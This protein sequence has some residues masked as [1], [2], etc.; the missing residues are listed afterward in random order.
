MAIELATKYAGY[1]DELFKDEAKVSLFTN[2]DLK[3]ENAHTVKVYSVSTG[4]MND[5]GR[6]GSPDSTGN[7]PSRYG[8]V[9]PLS[10]TTQTMPLRKDRSFTFEIDRLDI[11]ETAGALEAAKALARQLREVVVPEVD[12][13]A[14]A[15]M[16]HGAGNVK[17]AGTD[18]THSTVYG[19]ILDGTETMDAAEV[20]EDNRV[21]IV[22]PS[23]WALIKQRGILDH[24]DV[25]TEA[26]LNG[27]IA[28][29]DGMNVVRIAAA[30]LPSGVD[31][32]IAHPTATV[33]A[34]KL[35]DYHIH[36]NPPGI[37]GSLVEGRI[38][39]DAYV[40]DNKK[41]GI[42]VHSSKAEYTA[43]VDPSGNP[44]EKGWYEKD[45]DTYELT[46]DTTVQ[47]G[48]TYY[49]RFAY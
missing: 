27:S 22:S 44:K 32:I 34:Q 29:L 9:A 7:F 13:Y 19:A 10:A 11:E 6:I 12:A 14:V 36:E 23:T 31:F 25:G 5:Y 20:P 28:K 2:Q 42:Y 46:T 39:Y 16:A 18:L 38:A 15:Q 17:F 3:W 43:V 41:D 30:R 4:S 26:R 21:L 8:A 48:T 33:F 1:V 45:G 47:A 24:S 35:S 40:F 49:S 37:S